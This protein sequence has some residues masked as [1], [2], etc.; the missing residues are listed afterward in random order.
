MNIEVKDLMN[1][2]EMLSHI[3]LGCIPK[4]KLEKIRDQ[5]VDGKDWR[6]ESVKIPVSMKIGG[7]NVNPKEF[8]NTWKEQMERMILN[9]AKELV[10]EKLGSVKMIEMQS[11]LYEYQEVLESWESEINWEVTNPFKKYD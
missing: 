4:D 7:V 11:K 9:S 8:F 2:N 6:N 5:Y 1:D 10:A 3:F